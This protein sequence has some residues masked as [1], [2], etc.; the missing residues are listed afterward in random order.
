MQGTARNNAHFL[1][2]GIV[3]LEQLPFADVQAALARRD[4]L[5][6]PALGNPD[7]VLA[8]EVGNCTNYPMGETAPSY[9]EAINSDLPILILQG[10]YDTRTLPANGRALAEQFENA[11]LVIVPQAGHETWGTGNCAAQIGVEFL[12]DPERTP[13]LSCLDV[14]RERF[15]LPGDSLDE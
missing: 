4:A 2:S 13:D 9:G 12:R 15:S 7:A 3:C 8:T 10:E 14:R 1:L 5:E 11:T 6:I